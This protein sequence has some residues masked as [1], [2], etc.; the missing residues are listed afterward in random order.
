MPALLAASGEQPR[1]P[2]DWVRIHRRRRFSGI[3]MIF[4]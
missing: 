4:V 2:P 3:G 1:A